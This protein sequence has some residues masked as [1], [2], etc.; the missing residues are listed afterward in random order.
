MNDAVNEHRRPGCATSS[1]D[2]PPDQLDAWCQR[3]GYPLRGLPEPVC[4]ECGRGFDP[5]DSTT[6]ETLPPAVRRK[7]RIKRASLAVAGL[8]L[9]LY[10]LAPRGILS[11]TLTFTCTQCGHLVRI[12]RRELKPPRWISFRYPSVRWS[13][14]SPS[15]SAGAAVPGVASP[16]GLTSTAPPSK[17]AAPC[18][19]HCFNVSVR[20]DMHNGGW[21][22]GKG[23]STPGNPLFI[24]GL[25]TTPESARAV[26]EHLMSPNNSGIGVGP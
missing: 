16:P 6:F 3:C 14:N 9:I 15:A 10:A 21:A 20:F 7:R 2:V 12:E 23:I 18:R 4:P 1:T 19:A 8:A 26:L 17:S 13:A 24:N 25:S 5:D 22:S 11:G